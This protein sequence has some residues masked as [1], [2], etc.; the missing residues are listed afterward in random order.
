M[1]GSISWRKSS[2]S[3]TGGN[4]SGNCVEVG[5]LADGHI[6]VRD[7]KNPGTGAILLNRTALH[8]WLHAIKA[9]A[10]DHEGWRGRTAG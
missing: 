3:G 6:A 7:S 1:L 5:A 2:Y 8:T 10:Y 9:G 4:G